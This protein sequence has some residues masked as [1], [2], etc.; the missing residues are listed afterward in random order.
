M[1]RLLQPN[2]DCNIL[3]T[4]LSS[5]DFQFPNQICCKIKGGRI[6]SVVSYILHDIRTSGS[7]K[8]HRISRL[9]V[10]HDCGVL[11]ASI[12]IFCTN[13]TSA[14]PSKWLAPSQE[15]ADYPFKN[16]HGV[17]MTVTVIDSSN[18]FHWSL[19]DVFT[20]CDSDMDFIS[21]WVQ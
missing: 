21:G 17:T 15:L 10:S 1:D 2:P 20:W 6:L 18:S 4:S 11:I 16:W 12:L 8:E 19:W 9:K 3:F 14:I 7:S 5:H 13:W